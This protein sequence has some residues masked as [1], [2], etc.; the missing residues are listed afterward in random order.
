[1]NDKKHLYSITWTQPYPQYD[2]KNAV[3]ALTEILVETYLEE[4][5]YDE[6]NI[7]LARIMKL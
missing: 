5:W 3:D 6:A 2:H 7:E 4:G 1:M